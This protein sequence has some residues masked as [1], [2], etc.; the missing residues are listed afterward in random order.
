MSSQTQTDVR[1]MYEITRT[2]MGDLGGSRPLTIHKPYF[3][4]LGKDVS[5]ED[6]TVE[7]IDNLLAKGDKFN[8]T[9]ASVELLTNEI[10]NVDA[11]SVQDRPSSA[12][13]VLCIVDDGESMTKEEL[14]NALEFA[15]GSACPGDGRKVCKSKYSL[16]GCG[17]K[18]AAARLARHFVVV[19]KPRISKEDYGLSIAVLSKSLDIKDQVMA[20]HIVKLPNNFKG[21]TKAEVHEAIEEQWGDCMDFDEVERRENAKLLMDRAAKVLF[22]EWGC[23]PLAPFSFQRL[24]T[25]VNKK[26]TGPRGHMVYMVLEDDVAASFQVL[27]QDLKVRYMKEP[28]STY[29][30]RL[31]LEQDWA[32]KLLP[33]PEEY[34]QSYRGPCQL[35]FMETE[36]DWAGHQLEAE[37][38]GQVLEAAE[39]IRFLK[40]KR[41]N[42]VT[43][44]GSGFKLCYNNRF[45][46]SEPV[47]PFNH[48]Q[49]DSIRELSASSFNN[50]NL[51]WYKRVLEYS[52]KDIKPKDVRDKLRE[53]KMYKKD[54]WKEV[55][56][57]L[58]GASLFYIWFDHHRYHLNGTKTCIASEYRDD[59][60]RAVLGRS[61][62]EVMVEVEQEIIKGKKKQEAEER[63]KQHKV[64]HPGSNALGLHQDPGP[65]TQAGGSTSPQLPDPP[66]VYT[67][68]RKRKAAI[69]ASQRLSEQCQHSNA[70]P[71]YRDEERPSRAA[72]TTSPQSSGSTCKEVAL[73]REVKRGCADITKLVSSLHQKRGDHDTLQKSLATYR[74]TLT[75]MEHN[76]VKLVQDLAVSEE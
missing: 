46:T 17:S 20:L 45:L 48:D 10:G 11:K 62:E 50:I 65:S 38:E 54:E 67:T 16:H 3:Q 41:P 44:C 9:K 56:R 60:Y 5:I 2:N 29:V 71:R 36:V 1:C 40:F 49:Q 22:A 12:L 23:R 37:H 76:F 15:R 61:F 26:L 53:Y 27:D 59:V 70:V 69:L 28:L 7:L 57:G 52:G 6:A 39:G 34:Y 8:A 43:L 13:N 72:R 51:E 35:R 14:D 33:A 73:V 19:A 64:L 21:L 30:P 58:C 55:A 74:K 75:R 47:L 25:F 24:M 66:H 32:L 31:Y 4:N 63:Q 18:A 68:S 42:R